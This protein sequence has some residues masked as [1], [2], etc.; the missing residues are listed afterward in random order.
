MAKNGGSAR[1]L[2]ISNKR[3]QVFFELLSAIKIGSHSMLK[4]VL[5]DVYTYDKITE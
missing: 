3:N 5:Q 1:S 2:M 4:L